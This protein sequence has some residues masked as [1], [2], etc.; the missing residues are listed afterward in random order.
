[1]FLLASSWAVVVL[2]LGVAMAAAEVAGMAAMAV[3]MVNGVL[4]K[5]GGWWL[6]VS[7]G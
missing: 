7:C 1:M 6:S 4:F 5:H 3:A 2:A